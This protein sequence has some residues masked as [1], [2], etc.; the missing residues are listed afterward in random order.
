MH[1]GSSRVPHCVVLE[2]L[3][4]PFTS[5]W[6]HG[7]TG[8]WNLPALQGRE[9]GSWRTGLGV[10]DA[11]QCSQD[12]SHRY[13][14]KSSPEGEVGAVLLVYAG[15]LGLSYRTSWSSRLEPSSSPLQTPVSGAWRISPPNLSIHDSRQSQV[16]P[17]GLPPPRQT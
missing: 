7:I 17:T 10:A 8:T 6:G 1:S 4:L 15:G 5:P 11:G 14:P 9:R 3:Q 12:P 13:P 16:S 2:G